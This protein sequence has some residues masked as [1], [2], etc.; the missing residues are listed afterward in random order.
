MHEYVR[1]KDVALEPHSLNC[2]VASVSLEHDVNVN[3]EQKNTI[4]RSLRYVTTTKTTEPAAKVHLLK[5]GTSLA[6][7]EELKTTECNPL[8]QVGMHRLKVGKLHFNRRAQRRH[9]HQRDLTCT[10]SPDQGAQR[11]RRL[12]GMRLNDLGCMN[13][14]RMDIVIKDRSS[15]VYVNAQ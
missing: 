3:L 11:A 5:K 7:V 2:I 6:R 13:L 14:V 12:F 9:W 10:T 8:N 15:P 4:T 1:Q